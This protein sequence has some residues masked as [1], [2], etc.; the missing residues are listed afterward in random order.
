MGIIRRLVPL[1]N[2]GPAP[3]LICTC[4]FDKPCAYLC[5]QKANLPPALLLFRQHDMNAVLRSMGEHLNFMLFGIINY[6]L[7]V[8]DI[9]ISNIIL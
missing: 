3:E 8:F 4:K 2:W 9:L 5:R 1:Q 7:V 6:V